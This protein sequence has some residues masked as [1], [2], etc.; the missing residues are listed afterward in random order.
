LSLACCW[1]RGRLEISAER[2]AGVL[3]DSNCL[4]GSAVSGTRSKAISNWISVRSASVECGIA[5]RQLRV[6]SSAFSPAPAST[7]ICSAR[8]YSASSLLLRAACSISSTASPGSPSRSAN[9]ASNN[10]YNR[11]LSR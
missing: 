7:A 3:R 5:L 8:R 4:S 1:A 2:S 11:W 9:S 10:W 6:M